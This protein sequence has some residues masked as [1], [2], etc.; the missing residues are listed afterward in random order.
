MVLEYNSQK[1]VLSFFHLRKPLSTSNVFG[2]QL[3]ETIF[4]FTQVH[5]DMKVVGEGV[6]EEVA[7]IEGSLNCDSNK[8][9]SFS[10]EESSKKAIHEVFESNSS[11]FANTNIE[12]II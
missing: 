5:K 3:T 10:T 4:E 2:V 7:D 6:I 11:D 9:L 1:R 12:Q 8:N